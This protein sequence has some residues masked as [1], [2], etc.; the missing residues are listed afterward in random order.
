[1]NRL[2]LWTVGIVFLGCSFSV[3]KWP[4]GTELFATTRLESKS[5]AKVSGTADIGKSQKGLLVRL[6][7]KNI[8]PGAHGIH[9]HEKGDCSSA[10]GKS[11]GEHFNPSDNRHGAPTA[12]QH[13]GGDFGNFT[14]S[15]ELDQVIEFQ[16]P[17]PPPPFSWDSIIGKSLVIHRDKDDLVSQPAG[18]SG[19]RIACGVLSK[20]QVP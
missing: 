15:K 18:N 1:M 14:A 20:A 13:H 9:V 7:L 8:E 16:V 12:A 11:A 19:D 6:Y 17:N 2:R 3:A 4:S 5:G 10:D